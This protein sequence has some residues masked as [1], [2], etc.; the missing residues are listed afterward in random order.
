MLVVSHIRKEYKTLVAVNDMSLTLEPGDI[1]GFI[2]PNGA[3]KTT[4]IRM[5]ATLLA[6]TSGTAYVD[7]IDV[8]RYPEEVRSLIGYMPDFFG[9]YDDV[10][11]WEYLDFFAAAYKVPRA[12]RPQII[13]DGLALLVADGLPLLGCMAADH[14]LDMVEGVDPL[15]GGLGDRG[16]AALGDLVEPAPDVGP[17]I[18]QD[19]RAPGTPGISQRLVGGVA[20]HLKD[21]VEP[22]Q[23][24]DGMLGAAA[25]GVEIGDRRWIAAAPWPVVAGDRPEVAGFGSLASRIE[26]RCASL[27]HEQLG[28][29]FEMLEQPLTQGV[30]LGRGTADPIRQGR[31]IEDDALASVDLAL[32]VERQVVAVLGAEDVGDEAGPGLAALDRQ[33]RRRRLH[34]GVTVAAGVARPDVAD[35][36]ER[37]GHVFQHLGDVLAALAEGTGAAAGADR[38]G[39]VAHL[40]PRQVRW[41]D[42]AG[43]AIGI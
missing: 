11:V 3:G 10:K 28:R 24:L 29:A 12:Q 33:A 9:V 16:V 30:E 15:Q 41:R 17:T 21:A 32:P 19:H 2:G 14:C 20:V 42:L 34:R 38:I 8:T 27:V 26:H 18:G 43:G 7:G 23:W 22:G 6:P 31:A 25:G 13:D 39:L 37:G 5:I 36:P 1:F 35:D 4:T 40:H